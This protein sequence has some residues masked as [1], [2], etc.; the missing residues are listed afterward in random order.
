[1]DKRRFHTLYFFIIIISLMRSL[2]WFLVMQGDVLFIHWHTTGV[3]QNTLYQGKFNLEYD[4]KFNVLKLIDT[5]QINLLCIQKY[6]FIFSISLVWS[7]R[8]IGVSQLWYI[9]CRWF[10]YMT[11]ISTVLIRTQWNTKSTTH[12]YWNTIEDRPQ[13]K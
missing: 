10:S 1:M 5:Q 7:E 6:Y 12:T 2:V 4:A 13:F 11:N 8:D 3:L 9:H